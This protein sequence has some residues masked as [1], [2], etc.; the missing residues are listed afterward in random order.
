MVGQLCEYAKR[1]W[2]AYLKWVN[3][4]S[5][6]WIISQSSCSKKTII[7]KKKVY[8]PLKKKKKLWIGS[9]PWAEVYWSVRFMVLPTWRVWKFRTSFVPPLPG[10]LLWL[11]ITHRVKNKFSGSHSWP[12]HSVPERWK[13]GF[14]FLSHYNHIDEFSYPPKLTFDLVSAVPSAFSNLE[15]SYSSFR[16]SPRYPS[17]LWIFPQSPRENGL[18]LWGVLSC[19]I[20]IWLNTCFPS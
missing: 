4:T 9:D 11:P 7:K 1:H 5:S 20:H 15:S 2:I 10:T 16:L 18:L 13:C 19:I 6:I 8:R 14:P 17:V 3:Y 12:P